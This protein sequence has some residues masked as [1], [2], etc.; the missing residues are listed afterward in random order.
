MKFA[1]VVMLSILLLGSFAAIN[2]ADPPG[3]SDVVLAFIGGSVSPTDTTGICIWYPVLLGDLELRSLFTEPLFGRPVVDKEHAYFI[4]VSDFTVQVLPPSKDFPDINFVALV[5]AGTATIY[6]S[7]RP[8]LRD[9]TDWTNRSTWGDP[10]AKFV[11]KAGLFLSADNG[12]TGPMNSTAV[13]VESHMFKINGKPFNFKDLV[14]NGMT[15]FETGVG[16]AEAGTCVA[17]GK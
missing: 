8:D 11:R 17:V 15:C 12:M 3:S 13:L 10:V 7:E 6:Y 14:P 2:A 4:W 16:A 9:W 1:T 5:P